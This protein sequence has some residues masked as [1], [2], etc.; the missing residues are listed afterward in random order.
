MLG[1]LCCLSMMLSVSLWAGAALAEPLEAAGVQR[2]AAELHAL[3]MRQDWVVAEAR[4]DALASNPSLRPAERD[5]VAWLLIHRLRSER[6]GALPARLMARLQ[7]WRP[8]AW[9][10]HE[11]SASHQIPR[12][13]VAG[14]ALGLANQWDYAEGEADLLGQGRRS[15]T[16]A[17][18]RYREDPSAPY[19]LGLRAALARASEGRLRKWAEAAAADPLLSE[20]L[21]P[22][23]WLALGELDTL[24]QWLVSSEPRRVAE[25]LARAR[26]V[27]AP[28]AF[29]DL[30]LHLEGHPDR[31]SRALALARLTDAWLA[32]DDWPEAW[33]RELWSRIDDP[34]LA[35][36][37]SLQLARLDAPRRW[38]AEP[39]SA[40][41]GALDSPVLE[42]IQSL[43]P[44]LVPQEVQR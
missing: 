20:A 16:E 26:S 30:A 8:Q 15:M 44:S 33:A 12:Y 9:R 31:A 6:P 14:Q 35:A 11:E 34:E 27:L 4:L 28:E 2:Q 41:P 40:P 18:A 43:R 19:A 23:L 36:T 13:N 37:V 22:E 42:R 1:R 5:A 38:R 21:M 17:L 3:V 32:L 7:D 39:A 29:V 24:G 25:L 10:S